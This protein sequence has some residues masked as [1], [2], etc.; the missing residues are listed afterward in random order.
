MENFEQIAL[1][2]AENPPR[3][4][5]RYVDDTYTVLRKDQAQK[6]TDYLNTVD[7]DIKWT[8]EGEVV[9]DIEGL[10]NRTERG[11]AFLDT[12]SV[13][14][15]DGTIKTRVYRKDTHTDQYLNFESNH[16]LEHKRGVVKTLAH[17]AKTVVSKRED[18]RKELEHLRGAFEMQ[19]LPRM[20]FEGLERR[21]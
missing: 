7:E 11:L 14:N 18:R 4:W 17:R 2:K 3:W 19:W 20:D 9:K 5:K 12:L 21:K 16:P 13:I 15:E 1:E 10:E 6:F 8:T